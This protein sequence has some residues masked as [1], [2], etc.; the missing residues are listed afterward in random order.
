MAIWS[1]AAGSM[2]RP[3]EPDARPALP[4]GM[5]TAGMG[6]VARSAKCGC[7]RSIAESATN[8][9]RRIANLFIP[10]T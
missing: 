1:D 8:A 7:G 5:L 10:Y 4:Y 6:A 9:I 3:A 2:Q